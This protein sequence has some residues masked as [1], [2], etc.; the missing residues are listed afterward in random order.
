MKV[1]RFSQKE[2]LG[3]IACWS[4]IQSPVPCPENLAG[5]LQLFAEETVYLFQK[6]QYGILTATE[7]EV[8]A[9]LDKH[10]F[11]QYSVR[12]WNQ[13]TEITGPKNLLSNIPAKSDFIALGALKRNIINCLTFEQQRTEAFESK[14][15]SSKVKKPV[16]VDSVALEHLLADY[17]NNGLEKTSMYLD[18]KSSLS[19][20]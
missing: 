15:K 12:K 16:V 20:I 5:V 2:L 11:N 6:N 18:L 7:E 9:I 10:L 17:E 14:Y 3:Y 8:S 13:P 19:S 4:V 1:F